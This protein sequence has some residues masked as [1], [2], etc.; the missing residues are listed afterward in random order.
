[1]SKRYAILSDPSTEMPSRAVT[2]STSCLY[3][4]TSPDLFEPH[5]EHGMCTL[6][7]RLRIASSIN[8]SK[9][10]SRVQLK[11]SSSASLTLML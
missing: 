6:L 1:M 9:V 2:T 11:S 10:F 7:V 4:L 8:H 3:R 5:S